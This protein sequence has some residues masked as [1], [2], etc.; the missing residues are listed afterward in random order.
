MQDGSYE[1]QFALNGEALKVINNGKWELR[2]LDGLLLILNDPVIVDDGFGS[3]S[4]S[5]AKKEGIWP[6][7]IKKSFTG[8]I[9]FPINEDLGFVF[10]KFK[11][12]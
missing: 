5:L 3:L 12:K 9:Y 10:K 6:I 7:T 11:V 1:Q 4:K 8:K 2:S